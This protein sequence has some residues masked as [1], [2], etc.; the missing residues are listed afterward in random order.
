MNVAALELC[1]ELF[2]LSGW[3]GTPYDHL[4]NDDGENHTSPAIFGHSDSFFVAYPAYDLGY[5]I[6]RLPSGTT[7]RKAKKWCARQGHCEHS[8]SGKLSHS[9]GSRKVVLRAL[10]GCRRCG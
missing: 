9:P 8:A 1:K 5:L 7:I 10:G 4:V 6:R 3:D 2:E